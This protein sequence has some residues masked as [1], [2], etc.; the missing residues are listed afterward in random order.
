MLWE[1]NYHI[2]H[3]HSVNQVLFFY[4]LCFILLFDLTFRLLILNSSNKNHEFLFRTHWLY[5]WSMITNTQTKTNYHCYDSCFMGNC[6]A[7][8]REV[9]ND[10]T[11]RCTLSTLYLTK[12]NNVE[13][14]KDQNNNLICQLWCHF[15][16]LNLCQYILFLLPDLRFWFSYYWA[17]FLL[18]PPKL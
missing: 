5:C 4:H 18:F 6:A 15:S 3:W 8:P 14:I 7:M 10:L 17:E 9:L 12:R 1:S 11:F 16:S 13:Y 2:L